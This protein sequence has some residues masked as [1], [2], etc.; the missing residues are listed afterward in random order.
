[1]RI[2]AILITGANGEIGQGL[3]NKLN[4][5][6]SLDIITLDL[7]KIKKI[8]SPLII[9]KISGNILDLE[10][11]KKINQKYKIKQIYHLA[12]LL[13]SDSEKNPFKAHDV[14]VNGTINLLKFAL[15]QSKI[16]KSAVK[17]FFPSTIAVYGFKNLNEKNNAGKIHENQYLNP[18]TIYGCNKLYCENLGKYFSMISE[19]KSIDFRCIRFPGI[20]SSQTQPTGG[21]SDYI[22]AML[23]ACANN[24]PYNC[25]VGPDAQI[26]FM[27]MFDAISAILELMNINIKHLNQSIYN[28]KAF[29]PTAEE[30]RKKMIEIFPSSNILYSIDRKKNN[31]VNSWPK[32]INDNA[33][34]KD[35]GWNPIH[36]LDRALSDY[37]IP[38]LNKK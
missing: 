6:N 3:I 22:P 10:I 23:H 17:F 20:I 30:F 16:Q 14:N 19:F 12:A 21:T 32:D 35:W 29:S 7:N 38:E 26:P 25:F 4:K 1:M 8:H 9:E 31:M 18:N 36:D 27:T 15:Q 34:K 13:S 33:A 28:V 24:K 5:S 11:Y 37:L 2:P